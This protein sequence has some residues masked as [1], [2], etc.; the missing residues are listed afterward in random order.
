MIA[1]ETVP[2]VPRRAWMQLREGLLRIIGDNIVAIWAFGGTVSAPADGPIGDLDTFV[3]LRHPVDQESVTAIEAAHATIARDLDIEWDSWY[4][5]EEDTRQSVPPRHAWLDRRNETWAIDRA[6]WLAG[7]Y[8]LLHGAAA[9]E[10]VRQPSHQELNDALSSE[11]EHLERHVEAGDTDPYEAT[12]AILNGSR[13]LRTIQTGDATISKREAG[14]W[15]LTH[16]PGQW[17]PV[18]QAAIRAYEGKA[19]PDDEGV[20]ARDMKAFVGMIRSE[21]MCSRSGG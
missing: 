9:A 6:M 11:V 1:L 12:Y 20:L 10:I 13:I 14:P 8:V 3:V 19:T 17:H 5:L 2:E 7:R 18:L 21:V 16:L 15:G 4:V